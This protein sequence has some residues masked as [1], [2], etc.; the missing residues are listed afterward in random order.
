[1]RFKKNLFGCEHEL[2]L[3]SSL[4]LVFSLLTY[5]RQTSLE[6]GCPSWTNKR[7]SGT[8]IPQDDQ[9]PTG[10]SNSKPKGSDF[11]ESID[12][13]E[14][15][16]FIRSIKKKRK[17]LGASYASSG[18]F[19]VAQ[20][21]KNHAGDLDSIPGWRRSPEQGNSYPLKYS[22]PGNPIDRGAWLTTVRGVA[23]SWA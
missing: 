3:P 5:E 22:C 11:S 7:V 10:P 12:R 16:R 1:M 13:V 17:D 4:S 19:L 9:I 8:S 15:G 6:C 20:M 18:A 2:R 14:S 23:K 21:V